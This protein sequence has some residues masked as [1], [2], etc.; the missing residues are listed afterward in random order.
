MSKERPQ[1][2]QY[3]ISFDRTEVD[4]TYIRTQLE[5]HL[6]E[7]FHALLSTVEYGIIDG[8]LVRDGKREPFINSIIEGRDIVRRLSTTSEDFD[9]EDAE[10]EGFRD[11]IDPYLS[12]PNTP[13]GDKVLNISP[14]GGKYEHNFYDLLT[15]KIKDGRYYVELKRYSSALTSQDYAMRLPGMDPENP[16]TPAEF[17]RHPIKIENPSVTA[18]EIHKTLHKEH[19]YMTE[20]DF[21]E[22]WI[23]V[24]SAVERYLLNRD[25]NSFNAVLNLADRVWD[26]QKKR[27]A[28]ESYTDYTNYIP[29]K[30]KLRDLGDEPVRQAPGGCP[31]KSGADESP[32]SVS[33]FADMDYKFDQPGP[34]KKCGEDVSC[35]P[36][37]I[38]K[39]C[40]IKIRREESAKIAA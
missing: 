11:V 39:P 4:K 28:G 24:Q 26:S 37:G 20:L 13:E 10:V 29:T 36:C 5:T 7:R 17:L 33:E 3:D 15:K 34:C 21:N 32:Y 31:G 30:E 9:R 12:D 18:E 35:G 27:K 23:G 1:L 2:L 38:C 19:D 40:D 8:H 22:I 14:R 6:K 25:A 16:P